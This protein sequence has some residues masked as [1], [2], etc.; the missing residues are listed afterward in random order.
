MGVQ[1]RMAKWSLLSLAANVGLN[2]VFIPLYGAIGAAMTTLF[3]DI[4]SFVIFYGFSVYYLRSVHLAEVFLVPAIA[5]G[6]VLGLLWLVSGLWAPLL[7]LIGIAAY[8]LLLFLFRV[9]SADDMR[10]IR[11]LRTSQQGN[12]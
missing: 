2:L 9:I 5:A 8:A 1:R 7:A 6:L 12:V 3:A 10:Y 11:Q 4:L